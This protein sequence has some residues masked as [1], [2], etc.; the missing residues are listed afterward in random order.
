MRTNNM[1]HE[2]KPR[3]IFVMEQHLGHL[4]FYQNLRSYVEQS[5]RLIS[6]WVN[7]TYEDPNSWWNYVP[8]LTEQ[9]RGALIGRSQIQRNLSMT[10]YDVALYNTQ[11]PAALAGGLASRHPYVLSTDI[12]P[13]QYD[14]MA[15]QY[16]HQADRPG[17]VH[18]FKHQAN[19]N[20][21]RNA[22]RILP[23]SHW[24]ASSLI[25][26]YEVSPE[27]IEVIAP[28]IDLSTWHPGRK[29]D[30]NVLR[31]LFVGG[32]FYRKGGDLLLKACEK[33]PPGLVELHLVTRSTI[34]P[35][36]TIIVYNEMTPNS[37]ELIRLYQNCDIFVLPTLADAFGIAAVEAMAAGLPVIATN[38]GGLTDIV[39]HGETGY[40]IAPGSE[41]D[42]VEHIYNLAGD[43]KLRDKL[44]KAARS[45]AELYFDM[46]KNF[47]RVVEI[48]CEIA[49]SGIRSSL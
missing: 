19:K 35:K 2:Q 36:D 6:T 9:I 28:G 11:V 20:L 16:Q 8:L 41:R 13:I 15:S 5:H 22:Q 37:S 31:I 33:L 1:D 25:N 47:N 46:N 4:A 30:S 49:G 24:T 27:R 26:D 29:Q 7:V 10:S 3:A 43:V 21:Y 38:V 42:L 40:L 14:T 17:L 45:R 23:W 32:D 12:T 44:G 39:A 48:M 34:P 18:H